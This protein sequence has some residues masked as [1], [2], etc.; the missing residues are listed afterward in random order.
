[1]SCLTLK[2]TKWWLNASPL[3]LP[4]FGSLTELLSKLLLHVPNEARRLADDG[5]TV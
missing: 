5:L 1:M 4:P 2:A 3:A